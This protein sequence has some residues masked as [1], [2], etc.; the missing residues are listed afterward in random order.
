MSLDACCQHVA[1]LNFDIVLFTSNNIEV[2]VSFEPR[3]R[4]R[5]RSAQTHK[6]DH[7]DSGEWCVGARFTCHIACTN[8]MYHH[9]Y[10]ARGVY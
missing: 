9:D 1:P 2:L 7:L 8:V 4:H 6:G 5:P 10:E 3:Q